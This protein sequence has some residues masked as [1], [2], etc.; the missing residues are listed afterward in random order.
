LHR[1]LGGSHGRSGRVLK[2]SPPTEF[3]VWTGLP[4]ASQF[5]A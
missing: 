2:I 5:I 4:V 1:R 3:D